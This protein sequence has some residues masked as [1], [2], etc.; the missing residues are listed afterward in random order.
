MMSEILQDNPSALIKVGWFHVK[1]LLIPGGRFSSARTPFKFLALAGTFW[2]F[3]L[4]RKRWLSTLPI[5]LFIVFYT[6]SVLLLMKGDEARFRLP[7]EALAAPFL[8]LALIHAFDIIRL[9]LG[10]DSQPIQPGR[11]LESHP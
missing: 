10:I 1:A 5:L 7:V 8:A 4:V 9:K 11:N 2:G 3:Y 6:G